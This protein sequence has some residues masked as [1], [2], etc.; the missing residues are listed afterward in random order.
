MTSKFKSNGESS[1]SSLREWLYGVAYIILQRMFF[2]EVEIFELHEW[3][4][5]ILGLKGKDYYLKAT[6]GPKY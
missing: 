5:S 6:H 4:R 1:L 2:Q 3:D